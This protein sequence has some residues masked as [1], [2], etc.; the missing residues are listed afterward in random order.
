MIDYIENCIKVIGALV[1]VVSTIISAIHKSKTG[2]SG[3][4]FPG[5]FCGA[6]AIWLISGIIDGGVTIMGMF[7]ILG[8]VGIPIGTALSGLIGFAL[9]SFLKGLAGGAFGTIFTFLI[10]AFVKA[11]F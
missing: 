7:L 4:F 1:V 10:I 6:I 11:V 5:V 8:I 3:G 2:E 9:G